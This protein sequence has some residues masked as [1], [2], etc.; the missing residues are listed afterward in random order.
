MIVAISRHDARKGVD[1]LLHALA[2]LRQQGVQFRACLVGGGSLLVLHRRLAVRLR[3]DDVTTVVG[4]VPDSYPYLADADVFVLP[5]LEEG[6][7]SLSL[8][9]A[10][11]AGVAVV[12]SRVDGIPEDVTDGDTALLVAPGDATALADAIERLLADDSL[13]EGIA[14]RGRRAFEARFSPDLFSAALGRT[15]AELGV[16]P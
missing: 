6:S 12:A 4:P 16:A 14:R 1:I 10:L 11:Q 15:Y 7:G 3:L 8:L 9:E 5:S 2:R 13:R